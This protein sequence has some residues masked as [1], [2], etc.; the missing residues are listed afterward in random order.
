[1][2]KQYGQHFLSDR[3]IL[4]RIVAFAHLHPEDTV[5]EIGPGAGALTRE[6]AAA[7]HRVI[8]IEI[9]QD[10]IPPLRAEMPPN[11][12]II[13][14]DALELPFPSGR[15]HVAGNLPYNVATPLLKR[16]IHMRDQIIDAT[17]MVQKEVAERLIAG[18]G[19]PNYG[20]LSVLIQYYATV[21]YGFT[22]PPGAF[23]PRPKVDSAVIRLDWKAGV[24]E[25]RQ[26]TDF[27]QQA[28]GSKRKKLVNNLLRMF[29]SLNRAQILA[30]IGKAGVGIDARPEEL[31]GADF[32][33]VYNQF[34]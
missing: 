5:L 17:V 3:S 26:F 15:F 18:P 34:R 23:K 20:A 4:R 29:P 32:L 8:A 33:R 19:S 10:L 13:E 2:K 28:F 25:A 9:D 14:G 1:L 6:L 27:V 30:A 22:V 21:S 31:S 11:V 16:F 24:P 12:E 7:A